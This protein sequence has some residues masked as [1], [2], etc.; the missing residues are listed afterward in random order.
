MNELRVYYRNRILDYYRNR[1]SE[2]RTQFNDQIE[3]WA[4]DLSYETLLGSMDFNNTHD[5][6]IINL[7]KVK[8]AK[9]ICG[10]KK[11][12]VCSFLDKKHEA[13]KVIQEQRRR[14]E[15]ALDV[16]YYKYLEPIDYETF[17]I[18][19]FVPNEYGSEDKYTVY[20]DL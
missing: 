2:T 3:I 17:S 13:I 7:V 5:E 1:E 14:A 19:N 20:G 6:I 18:D 8:F 4:Q 15:K 12:I 9:D 11:G 16:W 10:S